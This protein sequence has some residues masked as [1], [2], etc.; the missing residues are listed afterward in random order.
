MKEELISNYN[1]NIKKYDPEL[2]E[3]LDNFISKQV[4]KEKGCWLLLPA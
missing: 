2:S 4:L 3:I 1:H